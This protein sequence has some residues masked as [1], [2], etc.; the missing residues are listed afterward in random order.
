M[1]IRTVNY[2]QRR[3]LLGLPTQAKSTEEQ[4][5]LEIAEFFAK[6]KNTDNQTKTKVA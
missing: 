1:R 5:N 3:L 6:V 2:W 4:S